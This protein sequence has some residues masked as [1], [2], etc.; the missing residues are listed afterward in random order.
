MFL[1]KTNH[2]LVMDKRLMQ[3]KITCHIKLHFTILNVSK[4]HN[5]SFEKMW[6]KVFKNP[7]KSE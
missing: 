4:S 2:V 1:V 7:G 6:F 5:V 3:L